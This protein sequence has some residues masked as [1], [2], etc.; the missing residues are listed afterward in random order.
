MCVWNVDRGEAEEVRDHK[1]GV[2][3]ESL[4]GCQVL[5]EKQTEQCVCLMWWGVTPVVV[6]AVNRGCLPRAE[7]G[8][9]PHTGPCE[10]A[11]AAQ[12]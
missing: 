2:V 4:A 6:E 9:R 5:A 10:H 8:D 11:E 12:S 3:S 1:E 7:A